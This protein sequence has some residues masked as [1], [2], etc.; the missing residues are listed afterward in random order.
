MVVA[1]LLRYQNHK[2]RFL[3]VLWLL[4]LERD[5]RDSV[6]HARLQ[7]QQIRYVP[8]FQRQLLDLVFVKRISQR[9]VRGI[10]RHRL[11]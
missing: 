4:L 2:R 10:Q 8:A 9:R 1:N 6:G 11:S 7:R 3:W 5:T